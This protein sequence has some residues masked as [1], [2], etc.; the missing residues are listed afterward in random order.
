MNIVIQKAQL[1]GIS[2][3]YDFEQKDVDSNNLMKVKSD[4]PVHDD[5]KNAFR[6]FIPHFAFIC[7]Q[8]TDEKLVKKAVESPEDYL[9][10]KETALDL[11]FFKYYVHAI[12]HN[13]KKGN[14]KIT[15][16]GCRQVG[17]QFEE[18]GFQSPEI[19]LDDSSYIFINEL[20]EHFDLWKKEVLAYMQ[21]KQAPKSQM[22]M[23]SDEEEVEQEEEG[24]FVK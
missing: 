10:N 22:Q 5:L 3:S 15:I 8:V 6:N 20:I 7:E 14:N 4:V 18:I 9:L 17:E 11:T 2:L 1:N 19:D 16:I 12:V 24:A 21:G 13:T 23:F